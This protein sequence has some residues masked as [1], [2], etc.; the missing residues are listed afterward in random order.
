MENRKD[1]NAGGSSRP[2]QMIIAAHTQL[3]RSYYRKRV[4]ASALGDFNNLQRLAL[5]PKGYFINPAKNVYRYPPK[6]SD[7]FGLGSGHSK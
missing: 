5:A 6:M 2:D 3:S 7:K 1:D 4:V